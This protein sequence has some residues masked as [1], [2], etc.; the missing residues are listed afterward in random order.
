LYCTVVE[1]ILV[2]FFVIAGLGF[3]LYFTRIQSIFVSIYSTYLEQMYDSLYEL[4]KPELLKAYEFGLRIAGL[5]L[6]W[7]ILLFFVELV[8]RCVTYLCLVAARVALGKRT[9]T[10]ARKGDDTVDPC[11]VD[12]VEGTT[13][14]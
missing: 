11:K 9:T 4:S 13:V 5:I 1:N 12:L 6:G 2:Y 14:Q 7:F 10:T 3:P 8:I